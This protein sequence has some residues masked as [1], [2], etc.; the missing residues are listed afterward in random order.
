M[1]ELVE[2]DALL[3]RR[4][5]FLVSV[6]SNP[7]L[8]CRRYLGYQSPRP[9]MDTR[10]LPDI[11]TYG[12][13]R[14]VRYPL[15]IHEN[16]SSMLSRSYSCPQ[17]GYPLAIL[18]YKRSQGTSGMARHRL[19]VKSRDS[20]PRNV[21]S[22]PAVAYLYGIGRTDKYWR[23][24]IGTSPKLQRERPTNIIV[25]TVSTYGNKYKNRRL[26]LILGSDTWSIWQS[27]LGTTIYSGL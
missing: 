25:S 9:L 17:R 1:A 22:F 24:T 16:D 19:M 23:G 8:S 26:L 14:V 4:D 10:S 21:G 18:K 5:N 2:S 13:C 20:W 12:K 3:R 15:K 11:G 7:I 6:G 27:T